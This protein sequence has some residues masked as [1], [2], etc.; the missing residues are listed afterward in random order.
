[1]VVR[2]PASAINIEQRLLLPIQPASF[3]APYALHP[4]CTALKTL[5][6]QKKL[7]VVANMGMVAQPSSR[8]ALQTQGQK[9]PANLF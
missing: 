7:A 6:D 5:F 9:R 8:V 3:A 4:S 1:M 2:T